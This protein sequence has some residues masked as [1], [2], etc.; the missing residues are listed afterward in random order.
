MLSRCESSTL[1]Q[2]KQV[3]NISVIVAGR[4]HRENFIKVWPRNAALSS[5]T[6]R[7]SDT[8]VPTG[9]QVIEPK[10]HMPNIQA[11]SFTKK[12]C[13]SVNIPHGSYFTSIKINYEV[14]MNKINEL[15]VM[16]STLF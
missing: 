3:Q 11:L 5:P 14:L 7:Y 1:A 9:A 2:E 4:L 8:Q 12:P 10:M 15:T 16:S 13:N 6:Q